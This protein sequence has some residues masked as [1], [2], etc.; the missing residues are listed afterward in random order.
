MMATSYVI[1]AL[2]L[3][4]LSMLCLPQ[5]TPAVKVL[6]L[7]NLAQTPQ[8]KHPVCKWSYTVTPNKLCYVDE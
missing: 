1:T 6:T 7:L 3:T 2:A 8:P 5:T 4:I